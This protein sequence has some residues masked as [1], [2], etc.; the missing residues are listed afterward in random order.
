MSK[1]KR[2]VSNC[3]ILSLIFNQVFI[4]ILNTATA[5]FQQEIREA[6][7]SGINF[8]K[9]ASTASSS[10]SL[11]GG[12]RHRINRGGGTSDEIY[13]LLQADSLSKNSPLAKSQTLIE[14][15]WK[16]KY[17][18]Q[19]LSLGR[20][21]W[22]CI[23][24][25]LGFLALNAWEPINAKTLFPALGIKRLGVG[26][27][28]AFYEA[29]FATH[30]MLAIGF[31]CYTYTIY[32]FGLK[33]GTTVQKSF[34][35]LKNSCNKSLSL[36]NEE[37]TQAQTKTTISLSSIIKPTVFS[38]AES[39]NLGTAFVYSMI[40]VSYLYKIEMPRFPNFFYGAAPF[41][42]LSIM[43]DKA[44][45]GHEMIKGIFKWFERRAEKKESKQ[46]RNT[47]RAHFE[48][49]VKYVKEYNLNDI[50]ESNELCDH[51]KRIFPQTNRKLWLENKPV[52]LSVLSTFKNNGSIE[53]GHK[54]LPPQ[55]GSQ[56]SSSSVISDIAHTTVEG[57][58][59][60]IASYA[61]AK[62]ISLS[63]NNS[64]PMATT[65]APS[66]INFEEF[67]EFMRKLQHVLP[68][69]YGSRISEYVAYGIS[70][71]AF[72][73]LSTVMTQSLEE[74]FGDP[75]VATILGSCSAAWIAFIESQDIA[76]TFRHIITPLLPHKIIKFFW[77]ERG[78]REPVFKISY[79]SLF[80]FFGRG[81]VYTGLYAVTA[82]AYN[83]VEFSEYLDKT[84]PYKNK[85]TQINRENPALHYLGFSFL[86]TFEI[87]SHMHL[88]KRSYKALGRRLKQLLT[89]FSETLSFEQS[90]LA[91]LAEVMSKQ[92]DH[93]SK[94]E[95]NDLK[96][97]VPVY[98]PVEKSQRMPYSLDQ[99]DTESLLVPKEG[100]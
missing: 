45:T 99:E 15:E 78:D 21:G 93:F 37:E 24:T 88:Q 3:I 6:E 18:R 19:G 61:A 91:G 4:P 81:P 10:L 49:A 57:E 20:L 47:F 5:S 64:Q 54:A 74:L 1:L 2:I 73:G 7:T 68:S 59:A 12:I 33:V 70:L 83:F 90:T 97:E 95:L 43:A 82:W 31:A 39:I 52:P 96:E 65:L 23:A 94:E 86:A 55:R 9:S 66:S 56:E 84:T 80:E 34:T 92:I 13:P 25:I 71:G 16:E 69:S 79:K 40:M 27:E 28:E 100:I 48:E 53:D 32:K 87:L 35:K 17:T 51:I 44:M 60:D 67:Y 77:Q 30:V 76:K 36:A 29:T 63:T 62:R 46:L 11:N 26:T 42:A 41:L 22:A 58:S 85:F 89:P 98:I 8:Q 14:T 75:L 50:R 38:L 72:W